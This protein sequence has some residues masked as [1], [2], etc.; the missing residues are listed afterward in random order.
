MKYKRIFIASSVELKQER[1]ELVDLLQDLNDKVEERGIR[2]K[3]VL[4][5]Y[6]DS[7]MGA[8]RKEDEYLEKLQECEI[9]LVLFWRTLGEYTEEELKVAVDEMN[10]G[11]L[12][13]LVFVFFKEP[14]NGISK[15]LAQ[16]KCSYSQNYPAIP[17]LTFNGAKSLRNMVSLL[18]LPQ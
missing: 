18:L 2:F 3:P 17:A 15:E 10:G 11:R 6:M 1:K 13:K 8:K 9:C 4:W 14:D 7:S 5:E 16:L 12:P